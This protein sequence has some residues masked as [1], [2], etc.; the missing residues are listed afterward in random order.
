MKSSVSSPAPSVTYSRSSLAAA[1]IAQVH[2]ARLQDGREVI[3]K[4]R[5]PGIRAAIDRDMKLLVVILR[6]LASFVP[7]LRKYDALSLAREIWSRLQTET[8]FRQ[9]AINVRRF[10]EE[11]RDQPVVYVP[12]VEEALCTEAVLVQAFSHGRRID[13]PAFAA[14][15]P[16]LAKALVDLYLH[17]YVLALWLTIR[18]VEGTAADERE[19]D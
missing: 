8:D 4:V 5:R 1:S 2:R 6:V 15:G 12:D 16:R 14:D 11:F 9:E 13:D 10:V 3:V 17:Q 18:I 7:A 19:Q